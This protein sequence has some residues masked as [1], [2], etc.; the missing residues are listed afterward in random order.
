MYRK[1]RKFQKRK[2][3]KTR[4]F[5]NSFDYYKRRE[6]KNNDESEIDRVGNKNHRNIKNINTREKVENYSRQVRDR[7]KDRYERKSHS[8]KMNKE[9]I[10]YLEKTIIND[11]VNKINFQRYNSKK[12]L[13]KKK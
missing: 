7:S 3:I 12:R 10:Q 5:N 4:N 6:R 11:H 9:P 1:T 13:N 2:E 8:E